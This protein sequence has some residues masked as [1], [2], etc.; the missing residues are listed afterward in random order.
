MADEDEV[1]VFSPDE[2]LADVLSLGPGPAFEL[3]EILLGVV[4]PDNFLGLGLLL[5]DFGFIVLGLFLLLFLLLFASLLPIGHEVELFEVDLV[6]FWVDG[7]GVLFQGFDV[8]VV[9]LDC[10]HRV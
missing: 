3:L 7:F 4:F 5:L 8:N 10:R 1:G 6:A 9:I 2:L